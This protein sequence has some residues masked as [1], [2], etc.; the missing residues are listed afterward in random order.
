MEEF[1]GVRTTHKI[2]P[3]NPSIESLVANPQKQVKVNRI[4]P[5]SFDKYIEGQKLARQTIVD[6]LNEAKT[7][8]EQFTF[9]RYEEYLK[10]AHYQALEGAGGELHYRDD[11]TP[12]EYRKSFYYSKFPPDVVSEIREKYETQEHDLI[13]VRGFYSRLFKRD[14]TGYTADSGAH[15]YPTEGYI[16]RYVQKSYEVLQEFAK[17]PENAP[18]ADVVGKVAEYYQILDIAHPFE[19]ANQSLAM[20]ITNTM[21]ETQGI[22]GIPHGVLDIAAATLSRE[23]F[24]IYFIDELKSNILP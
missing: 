7:D 5:E 8:G 21:L 10:K 14:A 12:G 22:P 1:T 18:V 2:D 15:T 16:K 23:D 6:M 20:N 9:E 24:T 11:V 13:R 3:R 19:A 17:L 4:A